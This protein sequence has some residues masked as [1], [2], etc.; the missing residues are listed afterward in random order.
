MAKEFRVGDRVVYL[1]MPEYWF[2][3]IA[4]RAANGQSGEGSLPLPPGRDFLLKRLYFPS[5]PL[6]KEMEPYK[7]AFRYDLVRIPQ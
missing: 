3:I 1:P 5:E 4:T 7:A 6:E 2:E